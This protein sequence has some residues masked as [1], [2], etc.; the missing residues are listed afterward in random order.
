MTDQL[1]TTT[2]QPLETEIV[3]EGANSTSSTINNSIYTQEEL[4]TFAKSRM[5][6]MKI[7]DAMTEREVPTKV[8][9]IRVINELLT[10]LDKNAQD[11]AANRLKYQEGQSQEAMQATIVGILKEMSG[12]KQTITRESNP[13]V[14][15]EFI[16]TDTVVGELEINPEQ[17]DPTA[18]LGKED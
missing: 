7:V 2:Q 12:N 11:S 8:G 17:L 9:E 18:F 10:S 14:P 15:D 13:V 3:T 5:I 1:V 4:N 16:P 6:R